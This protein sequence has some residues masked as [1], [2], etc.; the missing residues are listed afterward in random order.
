MLS[1]NAPNGPRFHSP[2]SSHAGRSFEIFTAGNSGLANLLPTTVVNAIRTSVAELSHVE[3][4][5]VRE[6]PF[7]IALDSDVV[8]EAATYSGMLMLQFS[9]RIS[10]IET[11][12]VKPG[13][14]V[15]F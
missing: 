8:T 2:R 6:S 9:M 4:G 10:S 13:S 11:A 7:A 15:N 12:R 1:A 3:I 5:S 14:S